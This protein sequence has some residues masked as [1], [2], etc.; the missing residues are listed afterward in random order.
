MDIHNLSTVITPNILYS[1]N[2]DA[3]MDDSFLAIEAVHTLIECNEQMC[4]VP[5][6]IL[7]ILSDSNLFANGADVTTKDILKR[8]GD[9]ANKMPQTQ[10]L[11]AGH[12]PPRSRDGRA[13][14]T[15]VLHRVEEDPSQTVAWPH[16]AS[17]R[18]IPGPPQPLQAPLNPTNNIN[19]TNRGHDREHSSS[20]QQ[21]EEYSRANGHG[22]G[23]P[24]GQD[25]A[26][27]W[28][29]RRPSQQ[30]ATLGV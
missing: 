7:S 23:G 15:P 1:K 4:Q 18:H 20:S 12:T 13:P 29:N 2:K 19:S 25:D 6:D 28:N 30:P 26:Y 14:A 24:N 11:V 22:H 3:G 5:E 9:I 16:E 27:R 8:W 17:V 21:E 10:H